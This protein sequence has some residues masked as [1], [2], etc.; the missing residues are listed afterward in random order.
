LQA[1]VGTDNY[2]GE[3]MEKFA[4]KVLF[5]NSRSELFSEQAIDRGE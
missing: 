2:Y 5:K 3:L 4:G 1:A